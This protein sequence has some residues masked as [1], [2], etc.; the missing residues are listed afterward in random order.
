MHAQRPALHTLQSLLLRRW[1]LQAQP[2][3]RLE[4]CGCTR[5]CAARHGLCQARGACV[6]RRNIKMQ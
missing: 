2:L 5:V 3:E 4:S 6:T 1:D